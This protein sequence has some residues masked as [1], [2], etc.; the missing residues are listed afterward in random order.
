MQLP[1]RPA[2]NEQNQ[3]KN[4]QH[5]PRTLKLRVHKRKQPDRCSTQMH[6]FLMR[7]L[8]SS[9]KRR[10][11]LRVVIHQ[12]GQ[13]T[14]PHTP[15]YCGWTRLVSHQNRFC[16]LACIGCHPSQLAQG[17]FIHSGWKDWTERNLGIDIVRLNLGGIAALS[18]IS[19]PHLWQVQIM[20]GSDP[21]WDPPHT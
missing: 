10:L 20:P 21:S 14:S 17:L 9:I 1:S 2:Q 15:Y 5:L 13:T 6:P 19:R 8:A 12:V 16:Q 4:T 7:G 11:W 3:K 18:S